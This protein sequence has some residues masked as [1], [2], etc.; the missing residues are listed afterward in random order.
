MIE[1][2]EKFSTPFEF[3]RVDLYDV[4]NKMIFGELTF[5]PAVCLAKYTDEA[6]KELG[7]WIKL[8]ID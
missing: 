6:S 8:E 4:D 3:V 2:A 1:R 5:I 7:S